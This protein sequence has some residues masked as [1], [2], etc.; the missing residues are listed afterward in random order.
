M[1][2]KFT[3]ISTIAVLSKFIY[4]FKTLNPHHVYY[5]CTI[6]EGIFS[7]PTLRDIVISS[8]LFLL[9]PSFFMIENV[10][11]AMEA[12]HSPIASS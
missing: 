6:I 7:I 3:S 5:L 1:Y 2:D 8:P 12:A 11:G 4:R 10:D 9:F